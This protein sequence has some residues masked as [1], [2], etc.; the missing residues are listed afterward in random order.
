MADPFISTTDLA[1]Y[2][3]GTLDEARALIAVDSACQLLRDAADQT[4][5]LVVDDEVRLDSSG[6]DTLLLPE[7]P[8]VEVTSV[9]DPDGDELVEDDDWVLDREMGAIRTASLWRSFRAGR[10]AYTVTYTHGFTATPESGLDAPAWPSGLRILAL[11]V[12][13]RVYDQ[14]LARQESVGGAQL[15]Y[16]APESLGLSAREKDVLK[17]YAPERRR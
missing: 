17:K 14:Q 12:A 1:D 5:D 13:A 2:L 7:L 11:T 16:S 6:G 8:I 15:I 4:F 10:Q 9:L 3:G